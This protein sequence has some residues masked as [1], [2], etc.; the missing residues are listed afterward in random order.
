MESSIIPGKFFD[1]SDYTSFNQL[2]NLFLESRHGRNLLEEVRFS[3][4]K[5]SKLSNQQWE[6]L[7]GPEINVS[8]H[9]WSLYKL[10]R[11]FLAEQQQAPTAFKNQTKGELFS[12]NDMEMEALLLA[13]IIHNWGKAAQT[14]SSFETKIKPTQAQ[15]MNNLRQIVKE[16]FQEADKQ[17]LFGKIS[18]VIDQVLIK[19]T[20]RLSRAFDA[21]QRLSNFKIGLLAWNKSK[22]KKIQQDPELDSAFKWLANSVLLNNIPILLEYSKT[23]FP[24]FDFLTKKKSRITEIFL[25][26]PTE[27]FKNYS[28]DDLEKKMDEFKDAQRQWFSSKIITSVQDG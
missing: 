10:A 9:H 18:Q 15:A 11:K 19:Q 23:L 6:G 1:G 26:M 3:R 7:L 20:G 4:F 12:Y 5:P 17:I 14:Q 28:I 2:F 16:L 27:T 22:Q 21:I 25:E 13:A 8:K 24:V